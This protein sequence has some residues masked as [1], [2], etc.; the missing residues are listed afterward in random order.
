MLILL[1]PSG[2]G[3]KLT[4][5]IH[6]FCGG[7]WHQVPLSIVFMVNN[8]KSVTPILPATDVKAEIEFFERLGFTNVYDSLRY[9]DKLDYA[10]L[11]REGVGFHIQFQFEKDLP[12]KNAA[13]QVKIWVED[14]DSLEQEF[15]KKGFEIRRRDKTP[16]GTN[17]FGFYSP[18][19]NAVIFVKD[20]E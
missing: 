6:D 12:P 20:L 10:V 7:H 1:L 19:H 15:E 13:Q 2:G 17:E 3:G 18:A 4:D 8:L 11:F 5:L 14:L 9:S 16:W